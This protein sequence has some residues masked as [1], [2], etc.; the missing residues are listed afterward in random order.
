MDD[1]TFDLFRKVRGLL[2]SLDYPFDMLSIGVCTTRHWR[3]P[4]AVIKCL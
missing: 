4:D 2:F 3:T 1:P